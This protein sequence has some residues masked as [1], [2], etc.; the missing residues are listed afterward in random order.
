MENLQLLTEAIIY[1]TDKHS[2]Q[3][4][5]QSEDPYIIHPLRV[6]NILVTIGITDI[7]ILIGG[8]LHDVVEDTDTSVNDIKHHFGNKIAKIVSEV[9]NNPNVSKAERKRAQLRD[10]SHKSHEAQLIKLADAVDNLS[11]FVT[12]ELTGEN[13]SYIQIRLYFLWKREISR[14]I[15]DNSENHR[16]LADKIEELCRKDI[17]YYVG[18]PSGKRGLDLDSQFANPKESL[19]EYFMAMDLK[20]K[21]RL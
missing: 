5:K 7:N 4:R 11:D 17:F 8:V 6:L 15:R 14:V 2:D 21:Y 9:S 20:D 1:A 19:N 18:D 10:I 3:R 16:K 12:Q 13:W